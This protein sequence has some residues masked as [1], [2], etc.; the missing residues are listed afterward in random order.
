MVKCFIHPFMW[1]A[2]E[3]FSCNLFNVDNT[4]VIVKCQRD[5]WR[6]SVTEGQMERKRARGTY[7]V[8]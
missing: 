1:L 7:L 5:R 2:A 8:V 3:T 6:E 4:L